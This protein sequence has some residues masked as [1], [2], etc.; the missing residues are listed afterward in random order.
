MLVKLEIL[1]LISTDA[2]KNRK[3]LSKILSKISKK[4]KNC[5]KEK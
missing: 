3:I 5:W 2:Q 4:L 1:Q